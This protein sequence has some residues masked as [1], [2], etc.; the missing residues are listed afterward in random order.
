MVDLFGVIPVTWPEVDAWCLSVAGLP[1]ES[2]RRQYY[3]ER[4]NIPEKI[5]AAKADGSFWKI[6]DK[7]RADHPGRCIECIAA[8][9]R[10]A[11][12]A[13]TSS[14]S[15][16]NP[17]VPVIET[18]CAPDPG[19]SA[20]RGS[21]QPALDQPTGGRPTNLRGKA[22]EGGQPRR[23]LLPRSREQITPPRQPHPHEKRP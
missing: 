14:A 8:V 1:P 10:N 23:W 11:E 12:P 6:L 4:W 2:P 21:E 20:G 19:V 7:A 9:I 17:R 15:L 22:V 16:R 5:Q 18:P 13:T 3:I